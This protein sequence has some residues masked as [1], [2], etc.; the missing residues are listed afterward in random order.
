VGFAIFIAIFV[1][2]ITIGG[3]MYQIHIWYLIKR[4]EEEATS[5]FNKKFFSSNEECILIFKQT[6]YIPRYCFKE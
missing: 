2:M 3:L 6:G 4:H 1:V 5:E